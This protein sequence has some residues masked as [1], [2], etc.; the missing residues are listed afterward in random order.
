MNAFKANP[1]AISKNKHVHF[2][3][4]TYDHATLDHVTD[5][6]IQ[7]LSKHGISHRWE[8]DAAGRQ[9]SRYLRAHP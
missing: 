8:V 4:T 2:G 5:T 6:I 3:Q 1:P 7:A 9:D